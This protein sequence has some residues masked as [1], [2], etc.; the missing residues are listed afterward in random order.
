MTGLAQFH[1]ILDYYDYG[2]PT[3][4]EQEK[5]KFFA[6]LKKNKIYNPQFTYQRLPL[7]LYL[8]IQNIIQKTDSKDPIIQ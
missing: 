6:H 8:E 5:D 2:S 3:N 1:G 4:Y 7:S